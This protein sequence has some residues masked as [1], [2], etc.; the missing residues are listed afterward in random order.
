MTMTLVLSL[1]VSGRIGIRHR[2][3]YVNRDHAELYPYDPVEVTLSMFSVAPNVLHKT[4]DIILWQGNTRH[5]RTPTV[6]QGDGHWIS[7]SPPCKE[8]EG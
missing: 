7:V 8:R 4:S 2:D 6:I 5:S 1:V 3:G